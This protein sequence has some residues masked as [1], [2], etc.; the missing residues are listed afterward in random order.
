MV[1]TG[2]QQ[3]WRTQNI[4]MGAFIQ[5]HTVVICIW[6]ALLGT[7]QYDVIFNYYF[8]AHLQS[9]LKFACKFVPWYLH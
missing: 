8:L 4:F 6:C 2:A 1:T 9:F 7:S 5:W 3:Q